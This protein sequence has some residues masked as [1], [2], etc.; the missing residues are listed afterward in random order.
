MTTPPT[1]PAP[2]N[3]LAHLDTGASK[4]GWHR[5]SDM[6]RCPQLWAYHHHPELADKLRFP[7]RLPLV[8]G[9]LFHVGGAAFFAR[10]KA[11]Q[12]GD[13]KLAAELPD[14]GAA[15]YAHA[16]E[17]DRANEVLFP[18]KHVLYRDHAQDCLTAVVA[19]STWWATYRRQYTIVA[20]EHPV[21][22]LIPA[23]GWSI[24]PAV[25]TFL[26]TKRIDLIVR[27]P[28]GYYVICDHKTRG[29]KDT[30]RQARIYASSGQMIGYHVLG[31]ELWPNR[32][33]GVVALFATF[34]T[35]PTF[36]WVAMQSKPWAMGAFYDSLRY[37][38]YQEQLFG[39][40]GLSPW[41]YPK[42]LVGDGACETYWGD[43]CDGAE[44]CALGPP[45][46]VP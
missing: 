7:P 15:I 39:K 13:K 41:H 43:P 10:L 2:T 31:H 44:L 17:Q 25:Q 27:D 34:H 46:G 26:H 33:G 3:P 18:G 11:L 9:T 20:V 40:M 32:F 30:E 21:D 37:A 22:S 16:E 5:A 14:P 23:A 19:M 36:Q 12:D 29:R 35:P 38:E 4:R 45:G 42:V 28:D 24:D 1:P 8:R 6:L